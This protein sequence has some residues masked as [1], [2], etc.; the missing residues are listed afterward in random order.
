VTAVSHAE[1]SALAARGVTT[2]EAGPPGGNTA[3]FLDRESAE[4]AADEY[5]GGTFIQW[6]GRTGHVVTTAEYDADHAAWS[7]STEPHEPAGR[8][9]P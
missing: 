5:G 1:W 4:A 8:K 2:Y 3:V 7:D 9:R 6:D